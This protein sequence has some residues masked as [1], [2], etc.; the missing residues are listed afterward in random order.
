MNAI[1]Y[2]TFEPKPDMSRRGQLEAAIDAAISALDALDGDVDRETDDEDCDNAGEDIGTGYPNAQRAGADY[3]PGDLEDAEEE[4]DEADN[5]QGWPTAM[6]WIDGAD[7][8]IRPEKVR[9][10]PFARLAR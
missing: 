4:P 1:T 10:T 8:V 2:P 9:V 5:A 7:G 6:E 3:G